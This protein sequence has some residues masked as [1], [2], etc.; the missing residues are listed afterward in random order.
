MIAVGRSEGFIL[1]FE[2][3]PTDDD[4]DVLIGLIFRI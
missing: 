3:D 2:Q 1:N 4:L